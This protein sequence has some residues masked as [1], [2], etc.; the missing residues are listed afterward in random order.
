MATRVY[1]ESSGTPGV[2][3]SSWIFTNQST[4]VS[5]PATLTQNSGA[6]MTSKAG[7]VTNTQTRTV[8]VGRSILGPLAAQTISGTVK[9]QMRGQEGAPACNGSLAMAIK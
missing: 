8:A 3:P 9:G 5:V 1:T 2:T 7:T 6:A 4:P